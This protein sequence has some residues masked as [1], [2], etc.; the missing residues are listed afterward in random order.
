MTALSS[1]ARLPRILATKEALMTLEAHHQVARTI[2]HQ[3]GVDRDAHQSRI[4]VSAG[5][6]VPAGDEGTIELQGGAG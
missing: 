5:L 2:A 3:A 6:A 4:E 1:A